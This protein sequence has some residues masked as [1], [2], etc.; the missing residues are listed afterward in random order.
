M[1]TALMKL[2]E[3]HFTR[4]ADMIFEYLKSG[5]FWETLIV[6][7][8]GIAFIILTSVID[9]KILKS[10]SGNSKWYRSTKMIVDFLNSIVVLILILCILSINGF[11]VRKYVTSLGVIGVVGSFALQ[12]LL[13]DLTMGLAIMFEGYFK[14]GDVVIYNG[15][16][17]KVISFNVKT[18]RLFMIGPETTVS[19]CNRNISQIA[20][21]SDW[22]DV[23]VPIAYDVDLRHARN[24][25][26]ECARKIERLRHVY[27]CDFLN[28]QEFAESWVNYKLRVHCRPDKKPMV[29][30]NSNAVIQDVFYEYGQEFPLSIK[31][32]YNVDPKENKKERVA[33]QKLDENVVTYT[34]VANR[35]KDYELGKGADKS[36]EC[37]FDGSNEKLNIAITEAERY[38]VSENLDSKMRLRLRLLSEELLAITTGLPK[39]KEGKFYIEREDSDYII[40]FQAYSKMD[41]KTRGQ[42]TGTTIGR[43]S[44][45]ISVT[46]MVSQAIDAMI[47]MNEDDQDGI[48]KASVT[49]MEDS[50]CKS[51]G[52]YEWSYNIFKEKEMDEAYYDDNPDYNIEELGKSVLM[53]LSDDI[54]ISVKKNYISIRVLV[55]NEE[56][57]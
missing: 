51:E 55:K 36:K 56:D 8:I 42:L 47:Q 20:I 30:R 10:K 28:T 57:E 31:V 54:R 24:L 29:M 13:K 38:A 40:W 9:H 48:S 22:V 5:E 43:S 2:N 53:K 34:S 37:E 27:S 26:R 14:V 52:N 3:R 44:V 6:V 32:L 16:A 23:T 45:V 15:E 21:D 18:T 41:R 25:C 12:D 50:I 49:T 46:E 7:I 19:I 17:G 11:D 4:K 1:L 39:M 33:V 35:K